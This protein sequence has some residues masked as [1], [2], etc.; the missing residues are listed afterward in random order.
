MTIKN[1]YEWYSRS[2]YG[3]DLAVKMVLATAKK[4]WARHRLLTDAR[5][6]RVSSTAYSLRKR[7]IAA[8]NALISVVC[9]VCSSSNFACS[10]FTSSLNEYSVQ[11]QPSGFC[12]IENHPEFYRQFG[13]ADTWNFR[14]DTFSHMWVMPFAK[15]TLSTLRNSEPKHTLSKFCHI[16]IYRSP[17]NCKPKA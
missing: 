1:K 8:C 15:R 14:C 6:T 5:H 13:N 3:A 4:S 7:C 9:E 12:T 16:Y 10:T 11:D 17:C 2:Q